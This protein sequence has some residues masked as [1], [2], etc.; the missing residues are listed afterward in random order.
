MH[1]E[2]SIAFF[3]EMTGSAFQINVKKTHLYNSTLHDNVLETFKCDV[4]LQ[5]GCRYS[6]NRE[7]VLNRKKVYTSVLKICWIWAVCISI[8]FWTIILN[9]QNKLCCKGGN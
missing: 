5:K 2:I 6:E 9:V 8:L 4:H 3:L 7:V 1:K